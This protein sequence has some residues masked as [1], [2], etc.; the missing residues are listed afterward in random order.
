VI[1]LAGVNGAGKT[2]AARSLLANTLNVLT[3]VNADVIAQGLCG[4]APEK[5]ALQAGRIML[6]QLQDLAAQR[7][8]FAFETT[9]AG[10][11]YAAWLGSLRESGYNVH[12]FYFWLSSADIAIARVAARVRKGGHHIA[13]STIRQRYGRSVRNLFELYMPIVTS[14]KVYDN[15]NEV[16]L[17][18]EG[19]R[20]AEPIVHDENVWSRIRSF[21]D[22]GRAATN[23][24]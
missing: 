23:H 2:T 11:A 12:L 16:S 8:D 5:A 17:I 3:F 14:W 1:V 20:G 7:T 4:F 6:T 9:L 10:R 21:I 18:A 13:E 15:S 24:L 22:G 19:S